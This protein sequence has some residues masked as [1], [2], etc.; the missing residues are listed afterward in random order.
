M[1]AV[2]QEALSRLASSL[3]PCEAFDV[4]AQDVMKKLASRMRNTFGPRA[5]VRPCGAFKQG[6]Y[7]QN[8]PLQIRLDFRNRNTEPD[9]ERQT[10]S[11]DAAMARSTLEKLAEKIANMQ[12]FSVKERLLEEHVVRPQI[13]VETS[14]STT[15]GPIEMNISVG[16]AAS[17]GV[18]VDFIDRVI[19]RM[20]ALFPKVPALVRV[21]TRW[22]GLEGMDQS[23]DGYPTVLAWTLLCLYFFVNRGDCDPGIFF[24]PDASE[25]DDVSKL[26]A[27]LPQSSEDG[28]LVG[29]V[30]EFFDMMAGFGSSGAAWGISVL[31]GKSVPRTSD[32]SA[33]FYIEDLGVK[34]AT[35]EDENAASG[36]TANCWQQILA[37]CEAAAGVLRGH[38]A[39]ETS[40]VAWLD[41]L[42]PAEWNG[43]GMAPAEP[44]GESNR[45]KR[46]REHKEGIRRQPANQS[47]QGESWQGESRE[48]AHT[49]PP[50]AKRPQ[51]ESSWSGGGSQ[52]PPS[53]M[54]SWAAAKA[55]P[56]GGPQRPPSRMGSWAAAKAQPASSH[57]S[58]SQW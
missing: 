51:V 53:R 18:E 11:N 14:D 43:P 17:H 33:P 48:P 2:S 26:P 54:G 38:P 36:L 44:A 5:W 9:E 39:G 57:S 42:A 16:T 22:V 35:S 12:R 7:L 27:A 41:A 32:S 31:S 37:S 34:I 21:V 30:A 13:L 6:A 28:L 4:L 3:I 46:K 25:Q 10:N 24:E 50:P 45:A 23:S 8:S 52:K 29:D 1:S 49:Y 47:K 20:F 55:Q 15:G 58:W 56:A 19:R 40:T